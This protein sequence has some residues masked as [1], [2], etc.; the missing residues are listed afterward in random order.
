MAGFFEGGRDSHLVRG[1]PGVD[2]QSRRQI[3]V[4]VAANGVERLVVPATSCC[5]RFQSLPTAMDRISQT[6]GAGRRR[7]ITRVEASRGTRDHPA[8]RLTRRSRSVEYEELL[9]K[10][11]R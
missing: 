2:C 9:R 3:F 4:F 6:R 11:S 10:T 8:G 7:N 5:P 1:Q